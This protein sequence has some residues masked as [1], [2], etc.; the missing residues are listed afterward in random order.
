MKHRN[1]RAKFWFPERIARLKELLNAGLTNIEVAEVMGVNETAIIRARV[2][3][4]ITVDTLDRA[5]ATS[6]DDRRWNLPRNAFTD[7]KVS[8]DRRFAQVRPPTRSY[9]GSAW[10]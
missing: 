2:R 1:R 6:T 10:D 3:Y 5:R 4:S 8:P 7:V 9:T